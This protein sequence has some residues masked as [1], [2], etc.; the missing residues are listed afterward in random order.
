MNSVTIAIE[1]D[2]EAWAEEKARAAGYA[3]AS[4]YL[5][6]LVQRERDVEHLRSMLDVDESDA[7]SVDDAIRMVR[8]EIRAA[9]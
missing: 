3:S 9:R 7:L 4:E 2:T 8:A 5:A 6:Y 1:A